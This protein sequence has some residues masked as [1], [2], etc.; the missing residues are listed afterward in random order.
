MPLGNAVA[1]DA[2]LPA[3]LA[4][5]GASDEPAR[6]M[7]AVGVIGSGPDRVAA[8]RAELRD[9]IGLAGVDPGSNHRE[10]DCRRGSST[11]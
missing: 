3:T 11:S 6:A 8:Y 9:L 4:W 1:T 5:V 2:M 7:V 10:V